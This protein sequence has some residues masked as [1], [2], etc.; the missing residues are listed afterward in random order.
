MLESINTWGQYRAKVREFDAVLE[1]GK[2]VAVALVGLA[3]PASPAREGVPIFVKLVS[4]AAALRRLA[5]DP[6]EATRGGLWDMPSLS[7]VARCVIEAH[8]AFDYLVAHEMDDAERGFRLQLWELH[9]QSRQLKQADA[10]GWREALAPLQAGL[11]AQAVFT[12]LPPGLQTE[13]RRRFAAGE[14]PAFHLGQRQRC[15]LSGID[16]DW[17]QAVTA[18]LSQYAHTLASTLA[19]LSRLQTESPQALRLMAL[20][21]LAA[22]PFLARATEAVARLAPGRLPAPPSRT[23]RTMQVWR[24]VAR[25]GRFE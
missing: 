24:Q 5:A 7:A 4:H 16:A 6:A 2:A 21:L 9:D 17:Y 22:L 12:A 13:L 11:E 23:A 8:D 10:A 1:H 19:E 3:P 15:M 18:R 14:P 20:P 25:A